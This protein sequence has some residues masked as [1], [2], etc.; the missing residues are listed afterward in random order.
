MKVLKYGEI[1]G[2]GCI[3]QVF[4]I[5]LWKIFRSTWRHMYRYRCRHWHR[6]LQ[7]YE[8]FKQSPSAETDRPQVTKRFHSQDCSVPSTTEREAGFRRGLPVVVPK[9]WK[10]LSLE[11]QQLHESYKWKCLLDRSTDM[12]MWQRRDLM[13]PPTT[14]LGRSSTS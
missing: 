12:H 3:I 10:T 4:P 13:T 9:N 8:N 14:V 5:I 11:I 1:K 2:R 6:H 7:M